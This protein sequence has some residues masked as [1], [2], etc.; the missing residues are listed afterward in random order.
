MLIHLQRKNI[1]RVALEVGWALHE[2]VDMVG[3]Q[4]DLHTAGAANERHIAKC[5]CFVFIAL[6]LNVYFIWINYGIM[7]RAS[8]KN[9]RTKR[10]PRHQNGGTI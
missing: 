5:S 10:Q 9:F 1:S 4:R 6:S 8:A 3:A 7:Y 2:T